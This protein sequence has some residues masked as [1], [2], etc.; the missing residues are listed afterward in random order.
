MNL[1]Q[2]CDK[3]KYK[4]RTSLPKWWDRYWNWV[5]SVTTI[6]SLLQD[7]WFN[8]VLQ[9]NAEAV[10]NAVQEWLQTHKDAEL[11]FQPLSWVSKTHPNVMKFHVLYNVNVIWTEITYK[12]DISWCVDLVCEIDGK[13][14]NVDY[15]HAKYH[16]AKYLLQLMG[17][18]YLNWNDWMLVFTKWK[19][20][21]INWDNSYYDIFIELKDYFLNLL[22]MENTNKEIIRWSQEYQW[23]EN[24]EEMISLYE[25]LVQE[26]LTELQEAIE[27]NDLNEFLDAVADV[28]WVSVIHSYLSW[29]EIKF[30]P[31]QTLKDYVTINQSVDEQTWFDL[32]EELM[33][34]ITFSNFTKVKELAEDGIKKWKVIKW[35]NFVSPKNSIDRLISSYWVRFT[36]Q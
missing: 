2:F 7:E 22:K 34:I 21:I 11:F 31:I 23:E 28:Y 1:Q 20:K 29:T 32:F 26:E 17:Y 4:L 5:P 9:Y 33:F 3:Y 12:K 14:Y 18:K 6:L 25:K 13:L 24:K 8:K 10:D 30:N 16:S 19:L 36:V 15:K 27:Q 35:P